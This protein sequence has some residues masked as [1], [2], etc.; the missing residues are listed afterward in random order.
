MV[1]EK[2]FIDR[3]AATGDFIMRMPADAL[4]AFYEM[5][6]AAPLTSRR[7]FYDVKAHL[8][9]NYQNEIT[10]KEVCDASM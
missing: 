9:N 5:L 2:I 8:E 10:G 4:H 7:W 6:N 1:N 3:E